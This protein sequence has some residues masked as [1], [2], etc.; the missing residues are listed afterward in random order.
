[1]AED[2]AV[3]ARMIAISKSCAASSARTKASA[4]SHAELAEDLRREVRSLI[5]QGKTDPEIRE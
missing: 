4:A 5:R 2:P 3:E 1:M